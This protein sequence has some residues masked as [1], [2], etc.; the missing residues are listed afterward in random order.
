MR[1][2]SSELGRDAKSATNHSFSRHL[3]NNESLADMS[4][5]I[6]GGFPGEGVHEA[7]P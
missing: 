6:S 1:A 7:P 4:A 5:H 2:S 3:S